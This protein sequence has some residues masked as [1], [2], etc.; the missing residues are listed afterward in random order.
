MA[1]AMAMAMATSYCIRNSIY[2]ILQTRV[3]MTGCDYDCGHGYL[4]FY[5]SQFIVNSSGHGNGCDYGSGN[6]YGN[7]Y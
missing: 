7:G 1:V 5:T 6:D 4:I 3:D 2:S